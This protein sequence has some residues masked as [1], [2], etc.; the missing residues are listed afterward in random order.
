MNQYLKVM[1]LG[2]VSLCL[3]CNGEQYDSE[4]IQKMINVLPASGGQVQLPAGT[5]KINKTVIVKS[6]VKMRGYGK[7][8]ILILDS[9]S[10]GPVFSNSDWQKGNSNIQL[11]SMLIK[12]NADNM[13]LSDNNYHKRA[14]AKNVADVD[15]VAIYLKKS[16]NTIIDNIEFQSFRNE[17]IML[18]ACR[19]I[20]ASNNVFLDCSR[21]GKYD[22]WS[23]GA[24]YLR[25]SSNCIFKS[26]KIN[27]C[28]E[29]GIVIG[30]KSNYN[31]II[32]NN[33]YNSL[34]GEGVFIG[35]GS[36]N[37]IAHNT[38]TKT[39][40][41]GLGTGA[42]IAISVPPSLDRQKYPARNN[43]VFKNTVEYTGGSGISVY[44]SDSNIISTNIV[45]HANTNKNTGRGGVSIYD[46]NDVMVVGNIIEGSN[47]K[48]IKLSKCKN[49]ILNENIERNDEK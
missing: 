42:G 31:L 4:Y 38:I 43:F 45:R 13:K 8:T 48:G 39:S 25:Y 19:R 36:G 23:Q 7:K 14:Y 2:I 22:D 12:G 46:S 9:N 47:S 32:D 33:I 27:N 21:K 5:F 30:F 17:A 34:S 16:Q 40:S 3:S 20:I 1:I 11:S 15:N 37:T 35:C 44:R 10:K 18:I 29:G 24:V 41:M 6:G 26:N 28:F 49:C